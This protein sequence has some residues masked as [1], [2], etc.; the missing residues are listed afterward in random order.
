M[1]Q[2]SAETGRP[3]SEL[4]EDALAGY[5]GEVEDLRE[6]LD[7]RYD[8]IVSGKVKGIPGE[9]AIRLLRERAAARA[10]SRGAEPIEKPGARG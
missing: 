4:V 6:M 8:D 2:W 5:F 3:A 1:E 9:E 7:S 10:R